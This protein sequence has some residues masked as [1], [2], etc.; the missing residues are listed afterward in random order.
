MTALFSKFLNISRG[1]HR[2][3]LAL[4]IVVGFAVSVQAQQEQQHYLTEKVA[5]ELKK[6][7]EFQKQKDWDGMIRMLENLIK[8]VKADSYDYAMLQ[9]YLGRGYLMK[10]DFNTAIVPFETV[11][12]LNQTSKF[13]KPDTEQELRLFIIQGYFNNAISKGAT[14]SEQKKNYLKS[15]EYMNEWSKYSKKTTPDV[16]TLHAY[17]YFGLAQTNLETPNKIDGAYVKKAQ[18]VIEK[19]LRETAK[20]KENLYHLL[21]GCLQQQENYAS[22]VEYYELLC[23]LQP[24][25][26]QNWT[27]LFANYY[28]LGQD[29]NPEKAF[30]YS[31]R[32][33]VTLDR[34]QALGHMNTP[35]DNFNKVAIYFNLQQHDAATELLQSGLL[36]GGIEDTQK[37]WE[38][39][40]YSYQQISKDDKAIAAIKEA[41]K[42]YPDKGNFYTLMATSYFNLDKPKESYEACLDAIRVGSLEKP[43]KAYS[44]AANMAFQIRKFDDGLVHVN[45]ALSFPDSK[46]DTQLPRLKMALEES[47]KERELNKKAIEQQHKNL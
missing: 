16:S 34:A 19:A 8:T 46:E 14:L 42:R 25:N 27:Q 38:I 15:L 36:N 12:R 17:I 24:N 18:V 20:P 45:K 6:L 44:F 30:D 28:Q 22:V 13:F 10:G 32:A 21:I 3:L 43:Y 37:N 2:V 47:I 5:D 26:K 29:A 31:I 4:L 7:D 39:L 23:K 33:I 40:I 11:L 35:K 1:S 41:V 9:N